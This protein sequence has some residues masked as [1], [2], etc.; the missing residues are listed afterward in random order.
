MIEWFFILNE[1]QTLKHNIH[2]EEEDEDLIEYFEDG[3]WLSLRDGETYQFVDLKYVKAAVRKP[4]VETP[5]AQVVPM[6]TERAEA[7]VPSLPPS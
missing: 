4:A 1:N 3:H 2:V 6:P 7:N 5:T